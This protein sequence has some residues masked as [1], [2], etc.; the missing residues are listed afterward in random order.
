MIALTQQQ[1]VPIHTPFCHFTL[2]N[3]VAILAQGL[4]LF[5]AA[6]SR[7][8]ALRAAAMIILALLVVIVAM[9]R[10]SALSSGSLAPIGF[11]PKVCNICR[12]LTSS[13]AGH[14]FSYD[15]SMTMSDFNFTRALSNSRRLFRIHDGSFTK[16]ITSVDILAVNSW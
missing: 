1:G 11:Q 15:G 13:E 5:R 9:I 14:N 3:S 6:I 10:T 2:H 4:Q 16:V 12:A 7:M 8:A